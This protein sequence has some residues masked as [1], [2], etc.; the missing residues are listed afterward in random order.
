[1]SQETKVNAAEAEIAFRK[2]PY[3]TSDSWHVHKRI[4]NEFTTITSI[5]QD[6]HYTRTRP[7]GLIQPIA[8]KTIQL[9]MY[10]LIF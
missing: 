7:Y 10:R 2:I 3:V 8:K 6:Y 9:L 4:N 5:P 1:M